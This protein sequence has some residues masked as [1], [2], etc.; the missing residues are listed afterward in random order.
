MTGDY[1][2]YKGYALVTG[3]AGFIGSN[4]LDYAV[5]KYPDFHFTCIDKLSYVSNYTTVFLSKVLNQPNFRFLEM[6]LAT[7]YK[8]LYQFMVED[9]EI[10]KITH[11]INFAAESSV[12]RSFI[13]PLYFT[14][15][16]ILSTQNLL[17]C[18]RILL[19]KKEE[20][21][22]RLN[23]VHVSTD[24]VYGEQDEN[25]SV[26]EKSKLNPTSPYAASKAAVDLI[27]QSYRYSYK[28]SV[29]V[30]RANNVYGPRQ[31]EE[32]LIPMTLGKLKKF[33]NQKSQKT[34][35][36]KITLHGDGLHKRKYL[37]IYDFIKA[38]DLVW[39][40][41]GSEVYHSTLESKMS[42]QIFNI[43]SDDEID[44]LSLVKFICDYFLY[45]KLSLK[46]LDYSK[47]ITF[48]QDRN[49]NDLRY[50]LNYEKIKSL[51]WRPQ[52]PLETGLRKLIDEYY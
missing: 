51:G 33:I 4:F 44:N 21:R 13:D 34:M 40:K 37:H 6:D 23:F 12:D 46:N 45:R 25:A 43:G 24:E 35:Q 31:Y 32:K 47:Y 26:D 5:D 8:F 42:G 38:I 20:L 19:G 15:N 48:V 30:I 27:I 52:I 2:E 49:Y 7:N 36:D 11:I 10:N 41:Q 3:G 50:S 16:N 22:N 9:S 39:M 18:V 28:I 17:E 29:T 14:K 1:K